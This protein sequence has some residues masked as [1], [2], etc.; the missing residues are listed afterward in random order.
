MWAVMPAE[1]IATWSVWDFMR[2]DLTARADP[3]TL[4]LR[5]ATAHLA[6]PGGPIASVAPGEPVQLVWSFDAGF[7]D[8]GDTVTARI[9]YQGR[10]LYT[11]PVTSLDEDRTVPPQSVSMVLV[12]EQAALF[13][14]IGP[15]VLRLAVT[16]DGHSPGPYGSKAICTVAAEL[17]YPPWQW[18][19]WTT[20]TATSRD[21][22]QDYDLRGRF[23]NHCSFTTISAGRVALT[24]DTRNA[25]GSLEQPDV[26][27]GAWD[28][29][30]LAA[31]GAV[32]E[33][34]FAIPAKTFKWMMDG[35]AYAPSAE[36]HEKIYDYTATL[37]FTDI[38]GNNYGPLVIPGP[39]VTVKVADK[40][41][42]Y[43]AAATAA[44]ATA[45]ALAVSAAIAAGTVCGLP[46]AAALGA[47]AGV[48]TAVAAAA[49]S[50]AQDPPEPDPD[51]MTNV[52]VVAPALRP[53]GDPQDPAWEI[54]NS[55]GECV[56]RLI[57]EDDALTAVHGKLLGARAAQSS[58]GVER[59]TAA[60]RALADT[61]A[62]DTP[63][64]TDLA[65]RT[66]EALDLTGQVTSDT[67]VA[68]MHA[69]SAGLP[70][71]FVVDLTAAGLND[72]EIAELRAA[73]ADPHLHRL[74]NAAG[75][76]PLDVL[77]HAC[78][79]IG[80]DVLYEAEIVLGTFR[81]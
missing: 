46:A 56:M 70:E 33:H 16:G 65:M 38:Y 72:D 81:F 47:A 3:S 73:A 2:P 71:T 4:G 58:E 12:P 69:C 9:E 27:V 52:E 79:L 61:M 28:L 57:A 60:Y 19:E 5:P 18:W 64:I 11:S 15:R 32:A 62:A 1:K 41:E 75:R 17:L 25:H 39:T 21:W 7:I 40:K 36:A 59:Q 10:T 51:F 6:L 74:L 44:A 76:T 43:A 78:T 48:A 26:E 63:H 68:G 14:V 54:R 35:P 8:V 45:A 24:E 55:L 66:Q 22:K 34:H 49:A 50:K 42:H 23:R 20:P 29:P 31:P 67:I 80:R 77:A 13:Y 53:V 37:E 30:G